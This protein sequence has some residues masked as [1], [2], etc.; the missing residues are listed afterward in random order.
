MPEINQVDILVK[1]DVP[2]I[3]DNQQLLV[4]VPLATSTTYG[5]VKPDEND[6]II[7]N[8]LL[9]LKDGSSTLPEQ[10]AKKVDKLTDESLSLNS[11][12]GLSK[13]YAQQNN[14]EGYFVAASNVSAET[15]PVR[16]IGGQLKG[17]AAKEDDDLV[18]LKQVREFA[19][20]GD[21]PTKISETIDSASIVQDI[22]EYNTNEVWNYGSIPEGVNV[23]AT[24]KLPISAGKNVVFKQNAA[25]DNIEIEIT[26]FVSLPANTGN[27]G[28]VLVKQGEGSEW[29]QFSQDVI[30]DTEIDALFA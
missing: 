20:T 15:I 23:K 18:N 1:A 29:K 2:A 28:D 6:F 10:L 27:D 25:K 22:L 16:T 8:G 11:D 24:R 9:K 12:Q 19:Q 17:A 4:Y 3:V 14:K 30:F 26:D 21:T 13:I 5:L 7:D